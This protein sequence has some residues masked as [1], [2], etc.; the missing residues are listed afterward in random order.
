MPT[1]GW[2]IIGAAVVCLIVFYIAYKSGKK[3]I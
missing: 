3:V 1:A 2:V